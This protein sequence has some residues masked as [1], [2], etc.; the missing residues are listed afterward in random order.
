MSARSASSRHLRLIVIA[1]VLA[2]I[3]TALRFL[4]TPLPLLPGFLKLDFSNIPALIG[5]FALGPV[6][7]TAI[8]LIKNL[9]YLPFSSTMG[10]GE[11][12]DFVISASLILPASLIYKYHKSRKGAIGGMSAGS[13][14]MSFAA[15]P[16]MNAFVLVPF[17]AW[18]FFGSSVDAIIGVAAAVNP[19]INSVW[20]Y[21]LFAVVPFNIVK[22]LTVCLVTGLLYKPLS[23]LLHKYR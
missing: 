10:V 11:I 23:P 21:I 3:S 19:A 5:G 17:Y 15:G 8:L 22:C 16:L 18:L 20:T 12:A 2:A 4:E 6:A 9:I 1:G 13:A 14:L 7:G